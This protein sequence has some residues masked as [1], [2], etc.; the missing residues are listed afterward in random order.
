[1]GVKPQFA[2]KV[3]GD[4]FQRLIRCLQALPSAEPNV[5]M[6]QANRGLCALNMLVNLLS[7]DH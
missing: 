6:N 7:D 2:M 3:K 4:H 5:A 1:M